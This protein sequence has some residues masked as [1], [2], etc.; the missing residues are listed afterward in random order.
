MAVTKIGLR[1]AWFQFHKWIGL[2][3]AIVIIPVS[4]TG[5]ALVWHDAL[6][7]AVNPARY[8]VSGAEAALSPLAYAE[9]AKRVLAPGERISG[10]RFEEGGPV[11]VSAAQPP[12]PSTKGRPS[13]TMVWI[14][15]GTGRVLD[16]ADSSDGLVRVLHVLHGSLMVPGV[17][18]QIVGWIGVAMLI[19]SISGIWLWWPTVGSWT[20]GL[21]WRRHRNLDTNLHHMMG[22]WISVPLFVLSLTGVWISFP[23]FFAKI[24]GAEAP[25]GPGPQGRPPPRPLETPVQSPDSAVRIAQALVPGAPVSIGW[26]TDAKPEWSVS[27]AQGEGSPAEV[28]ITDAAGEAKRGK[29]PSTGIART[30]RKIHDGTDMGVVWQ[31]I[32]FL[33]GILPAILAVTGIIMWWRARS[34][35]KDAGRR[36]RSTGGTPATEAL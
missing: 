25:R 33:G 5:S 16:K 23:P 19:S 6:D 30:M 21:R 26:P 29:G 8:A 22:F 13:R 36:R 34:W 17:G 11:V 24:S 15:P 20:K 18:R 2:L 1:N 10:M 27:I 28:S 3:L 31:V 9:A 14:D 12:N 32:I 35:R 7:E 4:V